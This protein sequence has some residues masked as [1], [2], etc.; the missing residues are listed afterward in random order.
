[1]DKLEW[2]VEMWRTKRGFMQKANRDQPYIQII[3]VVV[4]MVVG[5]RAGIGRLID[6]CFRK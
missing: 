5:E 2:Y 1:L 4:V 6:R 3:Y